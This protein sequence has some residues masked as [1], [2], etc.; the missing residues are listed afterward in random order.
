METMERATQKQHRMLGM[1]MKHTTIMTRAPIIKHWMDVGRTSSNCN[2]EKSSLLQ[3]L[4][5]VLVYQ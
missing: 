1:K 2:N 5:T 3:M 4:L